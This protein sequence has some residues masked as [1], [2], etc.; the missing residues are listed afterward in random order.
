[1]KTELCNLFEK[2]KADKCPAILHTYSPVYF[3]LLKDIQISARNVL[4][5]G[6]GTI[7][8][9]TNVGIKDYLPGASIRGWRDFFPN[10]TI[11]GVDIEKSVMLKGDRIITS[12]VDQSSV[13]SIR[14]FINDVNVKFDFIIDDGSHLIDHQIISIYE[15]ANQLTDDGIYIIED[16]HQKYLEIYK[17]LEFPGL[18]KIHTHIGTRD[19]WDNFIAYKKI[20]KESLKEIPKILHMVWVGELDPPQYFINNLNKWKSLMPDWTY[21][22][23]T[24]DKMTEEHFDQDYLAIIKTIKSPAQLSDF[25]RFYVMN[26]WGGYY[27]DADITPLRTL[28]EL[29]T[30]HSIILCNDLPETEPNYMMCAFTAG[31]PNHP[32]WKEC[33]DECKKLDVTLP[34][35]KNSIPT[36]PSVLGN[37]VFSKVN[38]IYSGGYTQLPYWT[39]YRNRIG[40]PGPY[41]PNRIMRDHPQAFGNHWYA[42]SWME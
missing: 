34:Y 15:L 40:D 30:D 1:M 16:I 6:I 35:N 36:G 8:I 39:F 21:M 5:I 2:Y 12:V 14:N 9:M 18:I 37:C 10:A 24:N 42:A 23:W 11:Y 20:K 28:E 17:E 22:I 29:P 27:L 38:W 4:E 3:E 19:G 25:I 32:L 13:D 7:P 33:I 26:K 41:I 31:I